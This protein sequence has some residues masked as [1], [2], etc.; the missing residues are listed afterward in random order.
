MTIDAVDSQ[1]ALIETG[2][3][4]GLRSR[5]ATLTADLSAIELRAITDRQLQCLAWVQEGKSAS[6]IGGILGIS[7]RTVEG[8]LSKVCA[9]LNV[10][11][12]F[13]AVLKALDL[14]LLARR[15]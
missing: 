8:H 2:S 1:G 5:E 7:S 11:T 15:P 10:R 6:D 12:R 9:H 3:A 13:Q 14:G 4:S